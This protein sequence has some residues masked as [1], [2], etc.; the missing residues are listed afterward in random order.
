MT[1]AI[2]VCGAQKSCSTSFAAALTDHD[3][4]AMHSVECL[5]LERR[6]GVAAWRVGRQA[7]RLGSESMSLCVKRPEYLHMPE[8]GRRAA[9]V[10][11]DATAVV[12]LREPMSRFRS[13][14]HHYRRLGLLADPSPTVYLKR[15]MR[16]QRA[17]SDIR[18][19]PASF[20]FYAKALEALLDA[21]DGRVSIFF[22][23]EVLDDPDSCLR[24]VWRAADLDSVPADRGKA[25]PRLNA[26]SASNTPGRLGM[27]GGRLGAR[28]SRF[29]SV[30]PRR[31]PLQTLGSAILAVAP[32]HATTKVVIPDESAVMSEFWGLLRS[33]IGGF[34]RLVGRS[35]PAQWLKRDIDM[36]GLD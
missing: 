4:V 10:F 25:L 23:D 12:I 22:Q 34:E 29:G 7:E 15:W 8:L 33:D 32:A 36:S 26:G 1:K 27:V 3:Q 17:Y 30:L 9:D 35:V 14:F 24:A 28:Q 5:A 6:G 21:F 18:S 16:H 20:S 2:V 13:A 31:P 19:Q 11:A